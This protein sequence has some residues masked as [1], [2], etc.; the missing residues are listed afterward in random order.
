LQ[1]SIDGV[2]FKGINTQNGKNGS[3]TNVYQ[4]TDNR[5]VNGMNY[6]RVKTT[7][8]NDIE[9]YSNVINLNFKSS[10][11]NNITVYPNPVKGNTIGLQLQGLDK[12]D[13]TIRLFDN[14]GKEVY[15]KA[16]NHNGN[17]S[18]QTITVNSKLAAGNYTLHLVGKSTSFNQSVLVVE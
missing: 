9:R 6:Y 17:S 16:I 14:V 2:S 3:L 11:L 4:Y 5:P 13:Y 10:N 1:H 7:Q 12:G 8:L 18:S 15:K